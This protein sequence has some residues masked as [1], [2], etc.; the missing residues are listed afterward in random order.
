MPS[1]GIGTFAFLLKISGAGGREN[2]RRFYYFDYYPLEIPA[3]S[4]EY[5]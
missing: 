5:R 4:D 2:A 1:S 3:L